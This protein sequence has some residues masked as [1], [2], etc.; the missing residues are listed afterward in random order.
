[1]LKLAPSP[2]KATLMFFLLF[3]TLCTYGQPDVSY[4]PVIGPSE[5][6]N[7]PIELTS[8]PGD[9][10][11][12]LFI[13]EKAGLIRIWNG[14]QLLSTPFLDMRDEVYDDG[15]E[16][17][18]LSMAFHPQYQS[19]GFFFVYYNNNDG[20]ITVSRYHVSSNPNVAEPEPNPS[21]P[22]IEISKPYDNHNGG[23]LQFRP[24]GGTN[25][26]YFATGDGGGGDDPQN[27]SQDDNSY[28]GKMIRINVD[29]DSYT[30]EIWAKGLRNPFRWSFDRSTG[31]IWIGD[32]GQSTKEEINFRAGGS[33][34]ANYGWVC[35]EGTA[36]NAGAAPDDADCDNTG[37][38]V[39]PI[40]DYDI[41]GRGRSVIGGY[42]YRGNEFADL[43]GYYI[44]TDFFSGR[45]WLIRPDGSGGWEVTEKVNF[46]TRIA[47]ISEAAN[48]ALYAVSYTN[49]TV[50]KIVTPI[51][52]PLHL[53]SFSGMP[54]NGYNELK[55]ITESEESM[56]KYVVE[57]STDG[58][59]YAVAGEVAS[60]NNINRDVYTFRH[61]ISN[62][63]TIYYRLNL[64]G[65]NGEFEYSPVISIGAD[66]R[67]AELKIY[68]T[69]I[70]NGKLNIIS[71]HPVERI[72]VT[73][74]T[75]VQV[76]SKE[77]NGA[78]GYF[79]IDIP[80]VQKGVY[81]VRV[82]GKDFQKTEKIVIQ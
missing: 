1:M 62:T 50:F 29:D 27:N 65:L 17:G 13:V 69:S 59:R 18:L 23:H 34:G 46:P 55:W 37:P 71:R 47:S 77:M 7:Q 40:F 60:R 6:L 53:V 31:D 38:T 74:T 36:N 45:L 42:V 48:G 2:R 4:Q 43:K 25:Y 5:G 41:G 78:T 76:M 66:T 30:P 54:V 33:S 19:N 20:D 75:G 10:S 82:A 67:T 51:V 63:T 68:P 26:L 39:Q 61:S 73:N 57:Y 52:T 14:S 9:A 3:T 64:S 81:I 72:F 24:G 80:V 56:D 58:T 16:R 32:V 8:A 22:L 70:T 28:L 44:T 79:T 11:G 21:S 35:R 49:N 15:G 12:R